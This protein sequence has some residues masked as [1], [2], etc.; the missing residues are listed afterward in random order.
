[1]D[2]IVD[3]ESPSPP[4][5][6]AYQRDGRAW[7]ATDEADLSVAYVLVRLVDDGAHIE[8]VSVHANQGPFGFL[9]GPT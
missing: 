4:E 5:L 7:V 9:I 2:T 6:A 8:Q 3:D 1:M